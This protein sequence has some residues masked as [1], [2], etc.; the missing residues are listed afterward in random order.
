MVLETEIHIRASTAIRLS[1]VRV[2]IPKI[3]T[4]VFSVKTGF[5][6]TVQRQ[7]DAYLV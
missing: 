6:T 1:T 4:S 5:I 3:V 2:R 7:T